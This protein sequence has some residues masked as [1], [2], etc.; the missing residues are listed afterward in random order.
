MLTPTLILR[1]APSGALL[2]TLAT[3]SETRASAPAGTCQAQPLSRDVERFRG[4]LVFEAHRFL[5]HSTLSSSNKEEGEAPVRR[6]VSSQLGTCQAVRVNSTHTRQ[7][8]STR[9]I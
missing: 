2:L 5:Y 8:E 7:T 3:F 6:P 4:G 9:H 1:S